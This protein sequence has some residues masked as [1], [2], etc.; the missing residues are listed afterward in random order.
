ML[1]DCITNLLLLQRKYSV[2]IFHSQFKFEWFVYLIP[3]H[4]DLI[5]MT[6]N[7]KPQYK[8]RDSKLTSH[9][10][11]YW[12]QIL[13]CDLLLQL[14]IYLSVIINVMYIVHLI[15]LY[16]YII[17]KMSK[18]SINKSCVLRHVHTNLSISFYFLWNE[19]ILD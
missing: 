6:I 9:F 17:V 5:Y 16:K 13:E 8:D 1:L 12:H 7:S 2:I 4:L 3:Y 14:Y 10:Y 19:E 15:N 11:F 18:M